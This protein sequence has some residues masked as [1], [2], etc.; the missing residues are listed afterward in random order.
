MTPD[1]I[2]AVFEVVGSVAGMTDTVDEKL[3]DAGVTVHYHKAGE[4]CG[5]CKMTP[6]NPGVVQTYDF[7]R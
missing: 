6:S 2:N 4:S 3:S 1:H 5:F 7:S